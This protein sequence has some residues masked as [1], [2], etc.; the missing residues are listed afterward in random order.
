MEI[1]VIITNY[2][3]DKYLARSIRSVINQ[4]FKKEDY[5]IIVIDDFS[6]DQ[7]KQI[8]ESFSGHIRAIHNPNNLGLAASCNKAIRDALGTFVIRLDADDYVHSDWLKIHHLFLSQNKEMDATSSDYLE[9]D[10]RENVLIRKC[11]VTWPIACNTMY[12]VDHIIGLGLYDES[13][14]RE[15]FEFRKRFLEA[16]YQIYNI[17]LPLYRYTQHSM[18]LTKIF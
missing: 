9:V 16:K 6:M 3:Y 11:G 12:R 15:D 7:S 17:P 10:E 18:S 14:P 5:E 4:S 13:L 1:S 2:N 8:I